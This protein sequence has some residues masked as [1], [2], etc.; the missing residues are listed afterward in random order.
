MRNTTTLTISLPEPMR[1][2]IEA[3]VNS[4]GF[5]NV[6]EYFRSLVRE[7]QEREEKARLESLLLEGLSTGSEVEVTPE[8]WADLRAEAA[9][10]LEKRR[11][12]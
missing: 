12:G 8:F 7:A 5:G 2:F 6:S 10:R 3:Q 4:K 11:S 1:Q 9:Q